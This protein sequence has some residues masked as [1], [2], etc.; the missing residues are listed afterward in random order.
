LK[1]LKVEENYI[2]HPSFMYMFGVFDRNAK[3]CTIVWELNRTF[4]VDKSP[5]EILN[6]SIR[7]IGFDLRGAMKTSQLFLGNKH[8][9]PVMIN[10]IHKICVFPNKSAKHP[11]AM[12]FNPTHIIR[13]NTL[14][15]Q[16][17]V[18]FSNGLVII[19]PSK[20]YS[21]NHKLQTADQYMKMT[22]G[23][24]NNHPTI[25]KGPKKGA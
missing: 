13:T 1:H 14:R 19:V 17:K 23:I 10:P 12:W 6:D 16:T 21:F 25:K 18:E 4:I 3:L 9:C 24:S 7:C 2:I 22:N 20:L 8:M 15:R 11:D 5:L